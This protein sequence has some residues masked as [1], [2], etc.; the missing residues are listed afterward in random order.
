VFTRLW[1]ISMPLDR[2]LE[3]NARVLEFKSVVG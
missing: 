2:R 3:K 1:K